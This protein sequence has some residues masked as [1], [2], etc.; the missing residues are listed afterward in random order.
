MCVW[1]TKI[2]IIQPSISLK[3][4]IALDNMHHTCIFFFFSECS[5]L[6]LAHSCIVYS[7]QILDHNETHDLIY[8]CPGLDQYS[9]GGCTEYSAETKQPQ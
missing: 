5:K 3:R 1:N 8:D 2:L 7:T 9:E 4:G 6:S